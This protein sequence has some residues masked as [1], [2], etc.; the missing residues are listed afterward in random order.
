MA[1]GQT[2][3]PFFVTSEAG[4]PLQTREQNGIGDTALVAASVA[5]PGAG[6]AVASLAGL[7]VGGIY[8]VTVGLILTGTAETQLVNARVRQN[9]TAIGSLPSV[10]GIARAWIDLPRVTVGANGTID[11]VAIAAA[12]GGSVYTADITATRLA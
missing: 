12:T 6:I 2:G 10:S 5:A 9:A 11:V 8:H 4:A 7:T 3:N 1:L